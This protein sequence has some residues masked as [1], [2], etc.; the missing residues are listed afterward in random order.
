M[1]HVYT[2]QYFYFRNN[3][4]KPELGCPLVQY[5]LYNKLPEN[6]HNI[7]ANLNG[8]TIGYTIFKIR[9]PSDTTS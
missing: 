3:S 9:Q 5:I 8:F 4:D 6:I 2:Y 7:L 1:F